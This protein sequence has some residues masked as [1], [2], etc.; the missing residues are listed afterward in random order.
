[1]PVD[2]VVF[3]WDGT[4]V[5]SIGRISHCLALAA[6]DTGLPVL[7]AA[8]YRS[9]IGLGL[10]E[11]LAALYPEADTGARGALRAAYARHYIE[12]E[13]EP[14]QPFAGAVE[15]LDALRARGIRLAVATGKNRPG[16]ERAFDGTGLRARFAASRTADE[17][18]SKPDPRM[19]LELMGELCVSPARTLMVGDTSFDL[20]MA[21]RAG[22]PSIGM[23]HGA[24]EPG[25]LSG[26]DPVALVHHFSQ[27]LDTLDARLPPWRAARQTLAGEKAP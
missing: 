10:P 8:R 26:H 11:A 12:A 23:T 20:A 17:S 19:L 18:G 7:E 2:L 6:A 1:M 22:V 16:L 21:A 5:D 27:F 9:V 14:C 13:R 4:L 25:V 24:H 3:D 15:V